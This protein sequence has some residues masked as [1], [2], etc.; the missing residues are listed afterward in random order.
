MLTLSAAA[1]AAFPA[2]PIK[3]VG[4]GQGT[5]G[6]IERIASKPVVFAQQRICPPTPITEYGVVARTGTCDSRDARTPVAPIEVAQ[7]FGA[8][9]PVEGGSSQGG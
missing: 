5:S 9:I 2:A 4:R 7:G 6:S 8:T 3:L 1:D